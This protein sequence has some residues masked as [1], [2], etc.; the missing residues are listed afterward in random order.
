MHNNIHLFM[1][2][3]MFAC[4]KVYVRLCLAGWEKQ[5]ST[6]FSLVE[7]CGVMHIIVPRDKAHSR[8]S[9]FLSLNTLYII[10]MYLRVYPKV[11]PV[12]A[13]GGG[14]AGGGKAGGGAKGENSIETLLI[15]AELSTF[16]EMV[17]SKVQSW[18]QRKRVVQVLTKANEEYQAIEQKLIS[19]AQLTPAEQ[20]TYD[21]NS[22]S[23]TEKITWLQSKSRE[24]E[25]MCASM[26]KNMSVCTLGE[27]PS[28][29]FQSM[30]CLVEL[31]LPS[32]WHVWC[33]CYYINDRGS[34]LSTPLHNVSLDATNT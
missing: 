7:E 24:L 20:A 3:F 8:L 9:I 15:E 4:Q 33:D 2:R 31:T 18:R 5:T 30:E 19:G 25:Y 27:C 29:F 10:N 6:A 23:D 34:L 11:I 26:F 21:A 16:T 22:G 14:E 1:L 32:P 13:A 12:A 28:V 17:Q